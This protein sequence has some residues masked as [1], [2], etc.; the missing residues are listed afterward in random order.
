MPL[1]LADSRPPGSEHGLCEPGVLARWRQLRGAFLS[2]RRLRRTFLEALEWG[3]A[4][5]SCPGS[6]PAQDDSLLRVLRA[7][8]EPVVAAARSCVDGDECRTSGP[9]L[10]LAEGYPLEILEVGESCRRP[11][12]AEPLAGEATPP[13]PGAGP[14]SPKLIQTRPKTRPSTHSDKGEAHREAFGSG[15]HVQ[16]LLLPS[17][18]RSSATSVIFSILPTSPFSAYRAT[19]MSRRRA[20]ALPR[21]NSKCS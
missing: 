18:R 1:R 5:W 15:R 10:L 7:L 11:R 12:E 17:T 19:F 21:C 3:T 6:C 14:R 20:R 4:R 16:S 13:R 2:A 8:R 9:V